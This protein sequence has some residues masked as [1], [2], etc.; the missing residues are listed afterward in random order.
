MSESKELTVPERAAI[1]LGTAEH[2]TK[3]RDL[4]AKSASITAIKNKD[5]REECHS[6]LMVLK[7]T[8]TGILR[9]GK[10]ALEVAT[11]FSRAVIAEERRLVAIA[12]PEEMRLEDLRDEW[13]EARAA[14]KRAKDGARPLAVRNARRAIREATEAESRLTTA[15]APMHWPRAFRMI[16]GQRHPKNRAAIPARVCSIRRSFGRFFLSAGRISGVYS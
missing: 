14:E 13:D 6:A 12:E 16:Q 2:E 1:A 9:A 15:A 3:L 4:V 11:E 10:A 7:T 5:G 8:R